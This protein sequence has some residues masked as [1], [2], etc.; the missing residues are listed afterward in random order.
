MEEGMVP[1]R[2]QLAMN[3]TRRPARSKS[4]SGNGDGA[5]GL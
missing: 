2:E 1:L 3:S 4:F 5:K